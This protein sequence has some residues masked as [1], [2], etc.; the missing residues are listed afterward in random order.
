MVTLDTST[1]IVVILAAALV[2][3]LISVLPAWRGMHAGHKLPVWRFLRRR[4]A[5]LERVAALQ[6][7]LRCETCSAKGR[8]AQLLA[9]GADTPVPGCPN[10]ELFRAST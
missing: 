10:A 2:G 7:E 3:A 1:F 9:E 5:S 4:D 6:A 8:C